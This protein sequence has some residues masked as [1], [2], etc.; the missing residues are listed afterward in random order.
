MDYILQT[1]ALVKKYGGATILRELTMNVPKGS[2]YGFVGRNGA[3]KTTLIRVITSLHKVTSGEY[4]IFGIKNSDP[5]LAQMRKKIGA[6]VETP[7]IYLEMS[8]R[9]NLLQHYKMMGQSPDRLEEI[10]RLVELSDTGKKKAKNFSLGMRQRLGIAFA[11]AGN[12]E[13]LILD[14]PINGLDPQGILEVRELIQKL[15][16]EM[17]I[18]ILISSHILDELSKLATHYGFIEGGHIVKEMSAEELHDACRNYVRIVTDTPDELNAA[19]T[20]MNYSFQMTAPNEAEIFTPFSV[21][22]F[23]KALDKRGVNIVTMSLQEESLENYFMNLIGGN[24][25]A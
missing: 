3:G 7:S 23:V 2:I 8:A 9:D 25:Y 22:P 19:L 6:I 1:N 18:T 11:L 24:R 21:T 13:F 4:S 14:E 20:E 16:R 12:P 17:G 15:N 5:A 10:L